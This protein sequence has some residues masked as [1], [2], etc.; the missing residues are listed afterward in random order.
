MKCNGKLTF[1]T[2]REAEEFIEYGVTD[3]QN[4]VAYTCSVHK[5]WHIGHHKEYKGNPTNRVQLLIDE[6]NQNKE[7]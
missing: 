2:K 7:D 3:G 1:H 4:M 5:C 6:L